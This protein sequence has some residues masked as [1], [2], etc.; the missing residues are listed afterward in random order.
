MRPA[1]DEDVAGSQ[2]LRNVG[3]SSQVSTRAGKV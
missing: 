2:R 1:L 3:R